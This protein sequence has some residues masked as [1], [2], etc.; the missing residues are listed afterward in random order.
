[1]SGKKIGFN[2][3]RKRD[4]RI[5][6]F[7]Q[8]KITGAILKVFQVQGKG[9]KDLAR[10]ISDRVVRIL[11]RRLDGKVP[12][13]EQIQDATIESIAKEGFKEV[14]EA[15]NLYRQKRK[16]I[17]EAKWWLLSQNVKTKLTPNALQVLE[18][19]YLKKDEQ[20]KIIETPQQLFQRV[21]A[22]IASAELYFKPSLTD[23]ELFSIGEKFYRMM[24]SLE[25]LPNS[26]TLMNAGGILQQ[27]SA[28]FVLNI[29]DS[30][31]EIFEAVKQTSLIHQSGGGTGF[32]F[33][34][35]RPK[36]DMVHSTQGQAS[37]PLS[38]MSVF[39]AATEVVKQGGKRRGA[40]MGILRVDHPDILEF[41]TAKAEEKQLN[42][43]NIS[44]AITDDF[45]KAVRRKKKYDLV[46]PRGGQVVK[47]LDANQVFDLIVHYA[48]KNGEPGVIFID[49]INQ[50]NPTP[51]LGEIEATNP[52]IVDDTWIMTSDGPRQVKELIGRKTEVVVES[53]KWSNSGNGF[54]NTGMKEIY[55]LVTKEG[56]EL[57]LT[58]NHLIKKV[59]KLSR[60]KIES[61]WEEVGK[62]K[63]GD[64][65]IINV[66]DN[67]KWQGEHKE[68]EG[69]LIGLLI[70]DGVIKKDKVVLSS[71]GKS[72]GDKSIRKLVEKY[73]KSLPHRSDF[74]GWQHLTSR[75]EYRLSMGYL[76]KL[77][78]QLGLDSKKKITSK[79]EKA[80][81][82][83]YE[84]FLRGFF[85]ADGSVQG[86][87]INGVSIRL[88]QSNI[89]R[90]K[91]VQRMLLRLG[92]FSQLHLNRRKA[93]KKKLPD[94]K[95]GYKLYNI[96]SQHE[97]I[98]SKENI[99]TFYN[100]IGFSNIEKQKKLKTLIKSYNRK[101]VRE[102][103][104]ARVKDVIPVGKKDVYDIQVP[105]INAFDGNGFLLHNCGEQPLLGLESCNLG[106]INLSKMIV[107]KTKH[108]VVDWDKLKETIYNA[109][110]FLDNVIE[111]NRYPLAEI[112]KMTK[113][114][115]K[116]GLGIM[117]FADMLLR[118]KVP[119]NS[120]KALIL[121]GK[122]MKLVQAE[123][124][125]VSATLAET[126][127][128]FPNFIDSIYDVKGM[129]RVR[130]ATVTTIA[131]TGTIGIIAGCSSAI[132][133]HFAIS[134]IRKHVLGDQEM[135]E[136]N[137]I[138]EE[139]AKERGFWSKELIEEISQ[140][141]SL[142]EI[143]GIPADVK[144]IFVTSLDITPEDHIKMQSAFQKYV[145]NATSKTINF[146]YSA[147]ERDVRRSYLMAYRLNCKGVT[148]Y[149]N[150][151]RKQQV[152]N[153]KG[154]KKKAPK[155]KQ[156]KKGSD[157][158]GL[159]PESCPTCNIG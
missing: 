129:P 120:K 136:V 78:K 145:D 46:N 75:D 51:K 93:G 92:I 53:E 118:L 28:C 65:V 122:I 150:E 94:G 125:K 86:T 141:G 31:E 135:V 89:Q 30:M 63:Q 37:G 90:L 101:I 62:L 158:A 144:K 112:E 39:N 22:N 116:I 23:D 47:Q 16:E 2:Q 82:D 109:V 13:V 147:S 84:G 137:P 60:H 149:R 57:C 100:R 55:K 119:Y 103:F 70:G 9:D 66:N 123:G 59:S 115:R 27:L 134:Y 127:G 126:R 5:V 73:T 36:G 35:L 74:K 152:L 61:E 50:D 108:W 156:V 56:Y 110:H 6:A 1:M 154:D 32:N 80:S 45:M 26:P 15:Y 69:Y 81:A 67:C 88:A 29:N 18:S 155:D 91:A 104:V 34:R 40:N 83:F 19:R 79:I 41:I 111:I 44:V 142:Q 87:H 143:K 151:S 138:F 17:R 113:G 140:K 97:L 157:I 114:N 14:A 133:P 105:G 107:K 153:I 21:A 99:S 95:G 49:R 85:D 130:N 43:F 38:F 121:A 12:Q 124:R 71:W 148:L 68:Q 98:I 72:K 96:K 64:R 10:K 52:C 77:T 33:S 4:G 102:R 117:G 131:P 8:S 42:N 25:F 3:I 139:V 106:S 76:K 132:E 48:W 7:D 24:A 146:P 54:F 11:S 128:T 20:G 58:A 159:P